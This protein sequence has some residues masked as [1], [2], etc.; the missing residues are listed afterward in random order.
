MGPLEIF[1]IPSNGRPSST[2][3]KM[4]VAIDSAQT[5]RTT[6]TVALRGAHDLE[7]P[8]LEPALGVVR[9]R[10]SADPVL[11]A[12]DGGGRF[13]C[14]E[15]RRSRPVL[16]PGSG[17]PEGDGA[18]YQIARPFRLRS[19]VRQGTVEQHDVGGR[20]LDLVVL[21]VE[22]GFRRGDQQPEA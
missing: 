1:M 5:K 4:E 3:R 20:L 22:G 15:P 19:V 13:G 7:R 8:G 2:T 11:D 18:P 12:F 10:Q 6:T 9:G 17:E 14:V 21:G 16:R